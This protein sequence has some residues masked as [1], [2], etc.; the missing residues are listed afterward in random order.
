MVELS[1]SVI[2]TGSPTFT[3]VCCDASSAIVTTRRVEVTP[4][5]APG[6]AAEPTVGVTLVTRMAPGSNTTEPSG[7]RPVVAR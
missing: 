2:T 7:S 6:C 1:G 3:L 4:S 5:S